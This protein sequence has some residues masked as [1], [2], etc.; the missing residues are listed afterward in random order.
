MKPTDEQQKFIDTNEDAKLIAYAG[1]GKTTTLHHYIKTR[2]KGSKILYLAFNKSVQIEAE[3]KFK[4]VDRSKINL[5]I[6]TAHG[7]AY[8]DIIFPNK[9]LYKEVGEL[10]V[11]IIMNIIDTE[12]YILAT[13]IKKAIEFYCQSTVKNIDKLDYLSYIM[14]PESLEFATANLKDILFWGKLILNKMMLG[15]VIISHDFY[16]KLYQLKKPIWNYDYILFDEAQDASE[17]MLDIVQRQKGIK[18]FVGDSHQQIYSWRNAVDSLTKVQSKEFQLTKSFRFPSHIADLATK[19]VSWKNLLGKDGDININ[20]L[21]N[22]IAEDQKAIIGRTNIRLIHKAIEDVVINKT[23]EKPYFEGNFSNYSIRNSFSFI[24]DVVAIKN[25]QFDKIKSKKLKHLT[26]MSDLASFINQCEDA[27]LSLIVELTKIYGLNLSIL[28][29]ELEKKCVPNKA[30]ADIIYSSLHKSKGMEYD[31]VTL[32]DD[33]ITLEKLNDAHK[34][35][36]G[37]PFEDKI[38]IN[39]NEELNLLYVGITR[40]K[41][42]LNLSPSLSKSFK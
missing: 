28:V 4:D 7:M 17:L 1:G 30:Q 22:S 32:L 37:T 26:S 21:G 25:R 8:R 38:L 29:D 39:L 20:G 18:I 19:V 10:D 13:H 6:K 3:E 40:S 15:E 34:D 41:N 12:D 33:F 36:I 24:E 14:V 23:Y 5:D 2:P 27:Q 11:E 16:L 9:N 31:E 35:A 42:K